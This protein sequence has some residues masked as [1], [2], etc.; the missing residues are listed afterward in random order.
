MSFSKCDQF[1][2][3]KVRKS[4]IEYNDA[5]S[6]KEIQDFDFEEFSDEP[7]HIAKETPDFSNQKKQKMSESKIGELNQNL[8]DLTREPQT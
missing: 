7:Y 3:S 8:K 4:L 2:N 6:F 1:V 5:E